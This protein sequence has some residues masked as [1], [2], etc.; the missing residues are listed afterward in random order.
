MQRRLLLDVVVRQS[1]AVL[2][3]LPGE[4]EALL[5]GR[6]A[7]LVLD[8]RLHIFDVTWLHVQYDRLS[9]QHL[10]YPGG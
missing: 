4:D 6:N 9:S 8:L 7:L 3:L 2:E 10:Q 5:V 1:A